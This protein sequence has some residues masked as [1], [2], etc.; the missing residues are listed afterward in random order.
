MSVR[1]NTIVGKS[2]KQGTTVALHSPRGMEVCLIAW[3]RGMEK[4]SLNG[5]IVLHLGVEKAL[6]GLWLL[7]LGWAYICWMWKRWS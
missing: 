4:K 7:E 3:T 5:V 6:Q 1:K 2:R